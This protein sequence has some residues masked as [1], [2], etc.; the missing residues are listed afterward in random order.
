MG[1]EGCV[2]KF[3]EEVGAFVGFE[4]G[5]GPGRRV[6]GSGLALDEGESLFVEESAE[7]FRGVVGVLQYKGLGEVRL[8]A[9]HGM[10]CFPGL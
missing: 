2:S 7:R 1:V 9:E 8:V 3:I 4:G 6:G 5:G 10:Q